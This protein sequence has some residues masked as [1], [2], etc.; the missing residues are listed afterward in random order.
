MQTQPQLGRYV[1]V[2]INETH[3]LANLQDLTPAY[4]GWI[5]L[6][7][8]IPAK[9]GIKSCR[10]ARVCFIYANMDVPTQLELCLHD[11][12]DS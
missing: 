3:S 2:C 12:P 7:M 11:Q 9:V 10:F 5:V 8:I 6:F 1:H 4:F